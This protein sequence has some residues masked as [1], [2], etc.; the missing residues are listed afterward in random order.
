M[1]T[2]TLTCCTKEQQ[3]TSAGFFISKNNG[4]SVTETGPPLSAS[5]FLLDDESAFLRGSLFNFRGELL[6]LFELLGKVRLDLLGL[7]IK[8]RTA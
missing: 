8:E 5:E 4:G 7:E 3:K 1:I 6:S 2:A